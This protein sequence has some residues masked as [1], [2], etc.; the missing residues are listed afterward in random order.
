MQLIPERC[1]V[2]LA[3]AL[4]L[5]ESHMSPF[6]ELQ[7]T[8]LEDSATS[9]W[10]MMK[11]ST[12]V[13]LMKRDHVTSLG[14]LMRSSQWI[15]QDW[16]DD[17]PLDLQKTQSPWLA[18]SQHQPALRFLSRPPGYLGS[19]NPCEWCAG[20]EDSAS[21]LQCLALCSYLCKECSRVSQSTTLA[22]PGWAN[23]KEKTMVFLSTIMTCL[24]WVLKT[25][26]CQDH[27]VA[28]RCLYQLLLHWL[29]PTNLEKVANRQRYK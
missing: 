18:P 22:K 29:H 6:W 7:Y 21:P 16:T 17:S 3:T 15:R 13:E 10:S 14:S 2:T 1:L 12:Q 23:S 19:S 28:W 27:L 4:L 26:C 25:Y 20:Y 9:L 5:E 24:P 8:F 11:S